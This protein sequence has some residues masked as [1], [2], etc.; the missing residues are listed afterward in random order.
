MSLYPLATGNKWTYK[1]KDGSL[2]SNSITGPDGTGGFTMLNS[3]TGKSAVMQQD[4][5]NY[6]TDAY[7]PGK[8]GITLK[9][10]AKAGDTWEVHFVA[11]G[12]QSIL[13]MTVKETGMSKTVEGKSYSDVVFIEADSKM[14]MNGNVMSLNFF[15]QYYYAKGT[16]LI[17]TTS[18]YGDS[19]AL[20]EVELK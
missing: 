5:D 11:N 20:V 10:N 13:V 4:G 12:I 14:N 1:S 7:E 18:S 17:L 8:M 9:E 15:T 6:L 19:H 3:V 16:G 2:W